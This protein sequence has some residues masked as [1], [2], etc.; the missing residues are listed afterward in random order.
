MYTANDNESITLLLQAGVNGRGVQ[1]HARSKADEST[2]A[3]FLIGA[4]FR[5][6]FGTVRWT[7]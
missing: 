2:L 1:A 4:G 5:M 6:Y 7:V 3:A